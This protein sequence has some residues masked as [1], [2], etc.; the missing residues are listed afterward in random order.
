M[1]SPSFYVIHYTLDSR[2]DSTLPS[3]QLTSALSV[4][5]PRCKLLCAGRASLAAIAS[6]KATV[7]SVGRQELQDKTA[8]I[9]EYTRGFIVTALHMEAS[10]DRAMVYYHVPA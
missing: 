9:S 3:T 10:R 6:D 1:D 2:L 4:V 8:L 5:T 7:K